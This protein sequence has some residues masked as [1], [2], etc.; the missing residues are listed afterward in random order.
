MDLI[1]VIISIALITNYSLA[2]LGIFSIFKRKYSNP[3]SVHIIWI[4]VII[5][6]QGIGGLLYFSFKNTL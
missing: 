4:W 1:E 6:F 3:K 5:L 2:L